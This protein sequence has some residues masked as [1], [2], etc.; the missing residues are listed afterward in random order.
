M[1]HKL[2]V[3]E[4]LANGGYEDTLE[5]VEEIMM[6]ERHAPALCSAGC[7]VEPDGRCP[8]GYPSILIELGMI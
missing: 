1:A 4:V 2:T 7:E 6:D 5:L 3:E 8:H